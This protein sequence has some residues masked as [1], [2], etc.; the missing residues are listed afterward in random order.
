MVLNLSASGVI[1]REMRI[2]FSIFFC[3]FP[4]AHPLFLPRHSGTIFFTLCGASSDIFHSFLYWLDFIF[5]FHAS[6][7]FFQIKTNR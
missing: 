4:A 6:N 2:S 3:A 1:G 7:P 5:T